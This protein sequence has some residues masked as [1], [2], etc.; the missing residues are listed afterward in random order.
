M[1]VGRTK[2]SIGGMVG[3][4]APKTLGA[5]GVGKTTPQTLGALGM[6]L[7]NKAGLGSMAKMPPKKRAPSD[8]AN[9]ELL[10]AKMLGIKGAKNAKVSSRGR[11]N[12]PVVKSAKRPA[13]KKTPV[14]ATPR[15]KP[16]PLE[17]RQQ[18]AANAA[19]RK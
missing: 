11:Q 19:S 9:D 8:E 18:M 3:A 6:G 4:F 16:T 1:P 17:R 5:T 2:A 14:A 12:Q 7:A 15:R 10:M 13:A